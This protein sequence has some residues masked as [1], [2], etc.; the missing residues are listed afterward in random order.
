MG[1][2]E[3]KP[4][5]L[6]LCCHSEDKRRVCVRAA[7]GP[8]TALVLSS[9]SSGAGVII[10]GSGDKSEVIFRNWPSSFPGNILT[11]KGVK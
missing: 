10:K 1:S 7:V 4:E 2:S 11:C 6:T 9:T 8:L 3:E 5:F